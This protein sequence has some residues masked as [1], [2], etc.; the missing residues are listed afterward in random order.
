M[1]TS[2]ASG[3]DSVLESVRPRL[4][5]VGR[6]RAVSLAGEERRTG[7]TDRGEWGWR[8][9]SRILNQNYVDIPEVSSSVK[10][11]PLR[12]PLTS[13]QPAAVSNNTS[14]LTLSRSDISIPV[15]WPGPVQQ[16]LH[17]QVWVRHRHQL[18]QHQQQ[19]PRTERDRQIAMVEEE[20][21]LARHMME[22]ERKDLRGGG[23]L[24]VQGMVTGEDQA[25][26]DVTGCARQVR[27][28]KRDEVFNQIEKA[29]HE[30][31]ERLFKEKCDQVFLARSSNSVQSSSKELTKQKVREMLVRKKRE[32]GQ[33][34]ETNSSTGSDY[35]DSLLKNV[36]VH[37]RI[38]EVF[39]SDEENEENTSAADTFADMHL[40]DSTSYNN[41]IDNDLTSV[42]GG[43]MPDQ[44]MVWERIQREKREEEENVSGLRH[45]EVVK[46]QI[47]ILKEIEEQNK[48]RKKEEELSL[49]LIA[50]LSLRDKRQQQQQLESSTSAT[51]LTAA[52]RGA[53]AVAPPLTSG[54]DWSVVGERA[55]ERITSLK[56]AAEL[57]RQ[58]KERVS[59]DDWRRE[60]LER[61]EK[62][63]QRQQK[64]WEDNMKVRVVKSVDNF[65]A[66]EQDER[67][68]PNLRDILVNGNTTEWNQRR[69]LGKDEQKRELG[70]RRKSEG[71]A[72]FEGERRK[73]AEELRQ[74]IAT[75][76]KELRAKIVKESLEREWELATRRKGNGGG[77]AEERPIKERKDKQ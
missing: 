4:R 74:R 51:A 67:K 33:R 5:T 20:L 1:S 71:L 62:E 43:D 12:L 23:V 77:V 36:K 8:E 58:R 55:K 7:L 65:Q 73:A 57:D 66:V 37:R 25:R 44:Q 21:R 59:L 26:M 17:Q 14:G 45:N 56:I 35:K 68:G 6:G 13:S 63:R 9:V 31:C 60:M 50:E 34:T 75:Q 39:N 30:E 41:I 48:L 42:L 61:E 52:D 46:E 40:P 27:I 69:K 38:K 2:P 11:V 70:A 22:V 15:S 3:Q 19:V 18:E 64:K 29:R 16:L 32:M 10:P 72:E 28:D 54:E 24:D 49:K 47:E 53:A 76:E